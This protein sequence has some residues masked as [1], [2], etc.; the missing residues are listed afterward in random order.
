MKTWIAL[1]KTVFDTS[2]I[3]FLREDEIERC[4]VLVEQSLTFAPKVFFSALPAELRPTKDIVLP[5]EPKLGSELDFCT[6]LVGF[7]EIEDARWH[8]LMCETADLET[9]R[10]P[11]FTAPKSWTMAHILKALGA[12]KSVSDA[13]RNGWDKPIPEGF[14]DHRCRIDRLKG[15]VMTVRPTKAVLTPGSWDACSESANG[16]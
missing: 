15:V 1:D 3:K 10:A 13:K 5:Q 11:I 14:T 8:T 4:P 9:R 2:F 12:F 6:V 7:D 16:D